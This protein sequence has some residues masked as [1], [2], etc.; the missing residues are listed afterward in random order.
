MKNKL[1]KEKDKKGNLFTGMF[2]KW[3]FWVVA[4]LIKYVLVYYNIYSKTLFDLFLYS[5]IDAY[6]IFLIGLLLPFFQEK[7]LK[8][9]KNK[10]NRM[11]I[12][13][14]IATYDGMKYCFKE[15]LE[16]LKNIDYTNYDILFVD[17]SRKIDFYNEIKVLEKIHSKKYSI[18]VIHDNVDLE[19]GLFRLISS[20]NKIMEYAKKNNYDYLLM[21]DADVM[22]NT[23]I[24]KELMKWNKDII[25]GFYLQAINKEGK[26]YGSSPVSIRMPKEEY[27][28]LLKLNMLSEETKNLSINEMVRSLTEQEI[29]E[30]RLFEVTMCAG[31]CMLLSRKAIEKLDYGYLG[32]G[33][34]DNYFM[35]KAVEKG[36][37]IYCY[38]KVFCQHLLSNYHKIHGKEYK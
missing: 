21:L 19:R 38:P 25:S 7:Y 11:K 32:Y 22:P 13:I 37:K 1:E 26:L 16:S 28:K 35:E 34:D 33:F 10:K 29:K 15:L 6:I 30:D 17:N 20:R 36:F 4:Y 18:K 9:K 23:N 27:D 14:G 24:I 12:L 5:L 2:N 3:Y 8:R 31:G